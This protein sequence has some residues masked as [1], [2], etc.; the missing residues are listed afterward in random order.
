[1]GKLIVANWKENPKTEGE[2]LKLFKAV[3]KAKKGSGIEVVTCPPFIY[4]EELARAFKRLPSS[5]RRGLS[6]GAQD[7]FWEEQGAFTS[8]VGPAMLR[9]LGA[10]YVILGHSERRKFA[11][12][13]D[14]MINK[15]IALAV[16]DK[17]K[18]ILCVGEPLAVRKK[19]VAAAKKFVTQ[20]LLKDLK[21][22]KLKSGDIAI[23]YEPIWAIGTGKSDKPADAHEMALFIKSLLKS[24]KKIRPRFLYG[25]SVNSKNAADY[26]QLK[27]IDGALVGGAS[28]KADEFK[29]IIN[30]IYK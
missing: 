22:I 26:V 15:K 20:Q 1:M 23:A 6:L 19:G 16:R 3:A 25:G 30:I 2:A 8:E 17:L 10:K 7:V 5:A 12:E 9:S 29:K 11:K 27:D 24:K 4:L 28:L 21:N 13:T 18:V 14:A